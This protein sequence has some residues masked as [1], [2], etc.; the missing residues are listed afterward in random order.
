VSF[1]GIDSAR[2]T[3]SVSQ[4]LSE[5]SA[6]IFCPSNPIVSVGPILAVPGMAGLLERA[7]SVKVAVSPIVGGAALKGPAAEMLQSLGHDVSPVGV[8]SIYTGVIDGI[9]IDHVDEELAPRIEQMGIEVYVTDTVMK[10][11]EERE[12]LAGA[13]LDFC[14]RLGA[15]LERAAT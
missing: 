8:A 13:V 12:T 10:G 7:R 11:Q 15:R 14:T 5:A 9:V 3:E 4:A 1:D 6:V 2:P